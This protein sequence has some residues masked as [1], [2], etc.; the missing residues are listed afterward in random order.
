MSAHF[1]GRDLSGHRVHEVTEADQREARRMGVTLACETCTAEVARARE[2]MQPE[3]RCPMCASSA[4]NGNARAS[5]DSKCRCTSREGRGDTE[6]LVEREL[7]ALG[8]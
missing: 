3:Q 6:D 2:L 7:G 8:S 1:T 4:S 5:A